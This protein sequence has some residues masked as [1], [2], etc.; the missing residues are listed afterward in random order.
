MRAGL[1]ASVIAH[2][3]AVF[4]T[5]VA[6]PTFSSDAPTAGAV[7]PVEVLTIGEYSNVMA[8]AVH[9]ADDENELTDPSEEDGATPD[10][11]SE[12]EAAAP[13]PNAR[14]NRQETELDLAAL[15]QD[16]LVDKQRPRNPPRPRNTGQQSD[17]NQTGAGL[18]TAEQ[19]A[20]E[21]RLRAL[22]RS[23]FLRHQCWREPADA[24]DPGR[25][26]VTVR[27]NINRN[28]GLEGEPQLVS[29]RTSGGDP[30]MRAAIENALRAV[31]LCDPFPLGD[32]PVA[33]EHYELW[34]RMEY[35]FRPRGY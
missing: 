29:P 27:I 19:V 2:V 18:G 31:R 13:S 35:T 25:L 30:E 20:L 6:W 28:G 7:V 32:D 10:P 33:A 9:A 12:A 26:V 23:H 22:M 15:N 16:L 11:P 17:R 5:L 4:M 34:R 3:G 8:L 24:T 14:Q 1:P 21:D